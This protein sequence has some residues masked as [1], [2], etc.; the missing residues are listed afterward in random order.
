MRWSF[1]IATILL[2][3]A[4]HFFE[5]EPEV[6]LSKIDGEDY[7]NTMEGEM[8]PKKAY[9]YIMEGNKDSIDYNIR[10]DIIDSLETTDSIWRKKHLKSLNII[11]NEVYDGNDKTFIENKL[12]SFFIHYPNELIHHLNNEGFDNIENWMLILNKGVQSATSPEDITINSVANAAIS[13]CKNC[14]EEQQRLI[15]E[16]LNKLEYFK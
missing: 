9:L 1:F 14:N 2:F 7:L 5:E 12:F 13:N 16:F 4:C 8:N 6:L 10:L 3:N 15:V 11:L